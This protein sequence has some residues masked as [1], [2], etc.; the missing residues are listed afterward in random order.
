MKQAT[1]TSEAFLGDQ[2]AERILSSGTLYSLH[3]HAVRGPHS[4]DKYKIMNER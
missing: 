1:D 4:E 3:L 2:T